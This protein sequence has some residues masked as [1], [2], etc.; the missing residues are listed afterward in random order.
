MFLRHRPRG[1][2]VTAFAALASLVV[3]SGVRAD[4]PVSFQGKTISMIIGYGAGGRID[5]HGRVDAGILA[6]RLP[7]NPTVVVRNVLGA[8]GIVAL[9]VF[10]TQSKPDGL[11]VAE[12][13]ASQIDPLQFLKAKAA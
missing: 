8:D 12:V 2:F 5:V 9:N 6:Q 1:M 13:G 11:T 3:T 10:W 7:G 4:E